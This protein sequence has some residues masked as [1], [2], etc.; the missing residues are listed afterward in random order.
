MRLASRSRRFI[1]R[2]VGRIAKARRLAMEQVSNIDQ[3]ER[4]K[5]G[6]TAGHGPTSFHLPRNQS[7]STDRHR[8]GCSKPSSRLEGNAESEMPT[9]RRGAR[10]LSARDV[11]QGRAT[12]CCRFYE[13]TS[14]RGGLEGRGIAHREGLPPS[15]PSEDL[16]LLKLS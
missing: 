6:H 2:K 12:G 8:D 15:V 10:N 1:H 5:R 7:A 11:S 3:T 4:G 9:L 16:G 14:P 13:S